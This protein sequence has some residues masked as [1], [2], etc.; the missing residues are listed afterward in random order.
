MLYVF[1]YS[2]LRNADKT[3][4]A[5]QQGGTEDE[6]ANPHTDEYKEEE[7]KGP[8]TRL[9]GSESWSGSGFTAFNGL[10]RENFL[11][12]TFFFVFSM[13]RILFVIGILLT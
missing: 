6:E 1:Y 11:A 10:R 3:V 7:T 12:G 13:R 4:L 2:G 5:I 8:D 9:A